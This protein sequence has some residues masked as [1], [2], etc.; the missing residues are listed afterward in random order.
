[1]VFEFSNNLSGETNKAIQRAREELSVPG[2]EKDR[3]LREKE[4]MVMEQ[5]KQEAETLNG[6]SNIFSKMTEKA[7]KIYKAFCFTVL[8]STS[9]AA[10]TEDA[11]A[12]R[13]HHGGNYS[14]FLK[15][16][17]GDVIGN[18]PRD[19]QRQQ[20]RMEKQEDRQ[21]RRM[22]KQ[23]DRW[24]KQEA[25]KNYQYEQ[26]RQEALSKYRSAISQAKSDAE[27]QIAREKY[28]L[29]VQA[30]NSAERGE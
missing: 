22:E 9:F 8:L 18:M 23:E 2:N 19:M 30:I 16:A 24:Q 6:P 4:E 29:E 12:G 11:E 1:M 10:F 15:E 28:D 5:I 3:L 26:Q 25:A 7:Q 27:L 17:V 21:Q 20:R 14:D 13:R